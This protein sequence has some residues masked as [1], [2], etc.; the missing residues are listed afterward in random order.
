MSTAL[1]EEVM[2]TYQELFRH[3]PKD[4]VLNEHAGPISAFSRA[5]LA[6][7]VLDVQD[8]NEAMTA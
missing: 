8:G 6:M 5:Q 7:N 4:I 2:G 1:E 3:N